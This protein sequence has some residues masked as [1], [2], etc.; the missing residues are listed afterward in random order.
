VDALLLLW[1]QDHQQDLRQQPLQ[2]ELHQHLGD[3]A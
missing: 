2:Q 3:L 1:L